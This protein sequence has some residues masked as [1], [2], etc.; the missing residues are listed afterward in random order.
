MDHTEIN[1]IDNNN[2]LSH[3]S[4]IDYYPSIRHYQI[5]YNRAAIAFTNSSKLTFPSPSQS[6]AAINFSTSSSLNFASKTFCQPSLDTMIQIRSEVYLIRKT[7]NS[8][9][10]SAFVK[11]P[12]PFLSIPLNKKIKREIS[13][14]VILELM[15]LWKLSIKTLNFNVR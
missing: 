4:I 9:F 1:V 6:P 5:N 11:S 14:A 8:H 10:I 3:L 13:S 7:I 12:S 15:F 2:L